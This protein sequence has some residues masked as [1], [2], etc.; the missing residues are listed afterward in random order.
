MFY[1]F[2]LFQDG[3]ATI[4]AMML[5]RG[6]V[7]DR[8]SLSGQH[9]S[10]VGGLRAISDELKGL[11]GRSEQQTLAECFGQPRLGR[12]WSMLFLLGRGKSI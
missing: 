9:R 10:F 8:D 6:A 7:E 11:G 5:R 4:G 2:V 12:H 1:S 3:L